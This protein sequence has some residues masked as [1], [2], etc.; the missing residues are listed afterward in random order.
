MS[1]KILVLPG[2]GIGPEIVAEALKVLEV[3]RHD[4]GLDCRTGQG[5]IGGAAYGRHRRAS[6]DETL[7]LARTADAVLLGAVGGPQWDTSVAPPAA[8]NGVC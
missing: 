7:T 1:K 8:R 6:P 3:L 4:Y 2:D 5:L